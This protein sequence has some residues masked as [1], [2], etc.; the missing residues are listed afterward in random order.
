MSHI[1]VLHCVSPQVMV[2]THYEAKLEDSMPYF[3]SRLQPM[4]I[5]LFLGRSASRTPQCR[6]EGCI[7]YFFQELSLVA[8]SQTLACMSLSVPSC[9]YCFF[10]CSFSLCPPLSS[11]NLSPCATQDSQSRTP[12]DRGHE[13]FHSRFIR[14]Y[15]AFSH[16]YFA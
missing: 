15:I 4:Q 13:V 7:Y 11:T 1:C 5:N 9:V 12:E 16:S 3:S 2:L 10:L 8:V 14:G 6:V